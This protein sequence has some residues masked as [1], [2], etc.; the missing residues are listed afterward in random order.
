M[1]SYYPYLLN[2]YL[3]NTIWFLQSKNNRQFRNIGNFSIQ[4][5]QQNHNQKAPQEEFR[6]GHNMVFRNLCHVKISYGVSGAER[7]RCWWRGGCPQM[8]VPLG[9]L[10]PTQCITSSQSIY[11]DY[12]KNSLSR[13]FIWTPNQCIPSFFH[14]ALGKSQTSATSVTLHPHCRQFEE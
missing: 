9:H 8:A 2:I 5:G 3:L 11:L 6:I 13:Y 10:T 14:I 1:K 12:V 4:L 7:W